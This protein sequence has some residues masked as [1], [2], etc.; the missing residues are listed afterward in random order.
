MAATAVGRHLFGF[1]M[2]WTFSCL[3]QARSPPKVVPVCILVS[4][5]CTADSILH[6][7]TIEARHG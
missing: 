7:G 6:G 3:W 4:V 5:P 1:H 2:T